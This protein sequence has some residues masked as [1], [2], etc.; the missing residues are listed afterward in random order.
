[1]SAQVQIL[2]KIRERAGARKGY[3]LI[4]LHRGSSWIARLIQLLLYWNHASVL[5]IG[6]EGQPW[7]EFEA[8]ARG[9]VM[10]VFCDNDLPRE[11]AIL[12]VLPSLTSQESALLLGACIGSL[13]KLYGFVAIPRIL[14]ELIRRK[15][16]GVFSR[17]VLPP[18]PYEVCSSLVNVVY[19]AAGRPL[20]DKRFPTPD[21]IADSPHVWIV[22]RSGEVE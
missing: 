13:G 5:V 22:M 2:D 15:L 17:D 3:P 11:W 12:D 16:S 7:V 14:W 4:L 10:N 6:G 18:R 20:V 8:R 21:D 19:T 9:V 1:M